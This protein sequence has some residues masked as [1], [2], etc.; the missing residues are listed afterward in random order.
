MKNYICVFLLLLSHAAWSQSPKYIYQTEEGEQINEKNVKL[1]PAK[2]LQEYAGCYNFGMSEGEWSLVVMKADSHLIIQTFA[3]HWG[4]DDQGNQAWIKDIQTFDTVSLNGARFRAGYLHGFFAV[5]AEAGKKP[6]H[7]IVLIEQEPDR[8]TSGDTAEYGSK[9]DRT[10]GD[11][12]DGRY[13]AL[14]YELK[15]D[16][17]FK[18]K[19]KEELQIMRNEIYARYGFRFVKGGKMDT[20]FRK[21]AWYLAQRDNV[22]D[23]LNEIERRNIE[24]IVKL[25]KQ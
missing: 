9:N 14:S 21:Q 4:N 5:Y 15:S 13:A 2:G 23:L 11:A 25:E 16:A 8:I 22:T 3:G 19:T 7:G 12:F 24:K 1:W 20:Y 17:W 6:E 10:F 18:L